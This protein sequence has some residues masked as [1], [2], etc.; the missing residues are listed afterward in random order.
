M[1]T[2]NGC[3]ATITLLI[4]VVVCC[5]PL[6][7]DRERNADL[8]HP[9]M[10][11]VFSAGKSF[12]QGWN[13]TIASMDEK[14]GMQS[15]FKYN[16]W[17]DT[18]EITQKQYYDILGEN[19][20]YGRSQYG[21]GGQYPVCFVTWFDA[22]L[23]CNARS[24]ADGLDSVYRYTRR[25][26]VPGGG[27]VY[28]LSD[29]KCDLSKDG[30]RLPT[31]AEW[32]FAARGGVS[33]LS[34]NLSSDL[35]NAEGMAWF[36][37]NS[38]GTMHP[39]ATKVSNTLG[40][41]DLAG[42]VFEWTNDWKG[43]YSGRTIVNSLGSIQ[44]NSNLEKVVKG[45]SYN[46]SL[47]YL[48]PS[49]RSTSFITSCSSAFE[50]VGFRCARGEIPGGR[51]IDAPLSGSF[52]FAYD[53]IGLYNDPLPLSDDGGFQKELAVKMHLFWKYCRDAD[54][55]FLGDAETYCGIDCSRFVKYNSFNMGF[56]GCEMQF[57]SAIVSNYLFVQAPRL[58]VIAM[59]V[60]LFGWPYESPPDSEML[61]L[62]GYNYDK[63]HNFWKDGLPS[64]FDEVMAR[65]PFPS[66]EENYWD[67]LGMRQFY[68]MGWGDTVP[69]IFWARKWTI[70]D[71][72]Y[73][74]QFTILDSLVKA[75]SARHIHIVVINFPVS[76]Y[77]KNT[78]FCGPA[79]PEWETSR[80]VIAQIKALETMYPYFHVYD[81]NLD[82]HHDYSDGDAAN[83]NRL[84]PNGAKKISDRLNNFI[85]SILT[86]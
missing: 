47:T 80:A 62:K 25:Y 61:H 4:A 35:I 11:N 64:G 16:Y 2:I 53:S 66:L 28:D 79:G 50:Q 23:F 84:C 37:E 56:V 72:A 10:K 44:G 46:F 36:A 43:A 69:D 77:F 57:I 65:Q 48:R 49:Y 9:G 55:I 78:E 76:P 5:A 21:V 83:A 45:G 41:Y 74:K 85:D 29:L 81:A 52:R 18:T 58:K 30:Y 3:K 86:R 63:N 33:A 51:Y 73:L 12:Y 6:S 22:V 82:G 13:D 75:C 15:D 67:S 31:E 68:C 17:I 59:N 24:K 54:L 7:N 39:V 20:V 1:F 27:N 38:S 19:P 14:P 42:N 70:K 8:P 71:S 26:A 32:E 40:L 60:P 34:Y